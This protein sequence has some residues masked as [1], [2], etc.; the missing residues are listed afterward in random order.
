MR[1]P[2][3]SKR[4]ALGRP[5]R[6]VTAVGELMVLENVLQADRRRRPINRFLEDWEAYAAP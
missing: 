4:L 6:R 2:L 5:S 3:A 1:L